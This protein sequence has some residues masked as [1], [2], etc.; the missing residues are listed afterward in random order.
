MRDVA[1]R[2]APRADFAQNHEC[3]GALAET[4]VNVGA[5]RLL[6]DRNQGVTSQP[7]FQL[8]HG[9]TG[10]QA[11]TDPWRLAQSRRLPVEARRVTGHL[12]GADLPGL[13]L[14]G[15]L[16]LHTERGPLAVLP[17]HGV[18]SGGSSPST[19]VYS[20]CATRQLTNRSATS[21]GRT[22]TWAESWVTCRPE[23]PQGLMR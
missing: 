11:H 23:K 15:V 20:S 10:R 13:L 2:A 9:I 12:G 1:E 17:G 22:A 18:S 4:F 6:A 16:Q 14:P 19:S 8:V 21:F 3:R 5:S 7:G